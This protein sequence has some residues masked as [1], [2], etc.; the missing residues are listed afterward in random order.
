[1][2]A[3]GFLNS[4]PIEEAESL[5]DVE[6]PDPKP[7]VNDLLVEIEAVSVNPADAKRRIR[8]AVDT[9][10]ETP[11]IL[12]Y[13]AVGIVVECGANV[14]GFKPGDRVWYAGDANRPGSYASL[15]CVDHRI[16]A[17]APKNVS[18]EAAASLPLVSLTA[19]EILF[20]RLQV[21]QGET[22]FSLL[23]IGGAGG[24][25]SITAQIARKLTN[26]TVIAT[27]SRP[28]TAKWCRQM[29]AHHVVNHRDL[30]K[31]MKQAGLHQAD[32]IVQY[33]DT[34][35]HWD[36][37]CELIAPQGRIG[38][39]VETSEKLDI[40]ALQGKSA[41]LMWELMFTRSLFG[42]PDMYKQGHILAHMARM[43]DDGTIA[44]TE[45][46]V[47]HGLSSDTLKEAHQIIEGA[48]MIGKLVIKY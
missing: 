10:H 45:T 23:I 39:I 1:M 22:P 2:R 28:E 8:T 16:A 4:L 42:T 40:S 18:P 34:A 29:G 44:T 37:M 21:P 5:F 7:E 3:V 38:T 15:Q 17:H 41:A 24:V 9:P 27:A 30:V 43:V 31:D 32:Y 33:A 36:A 6:L 47:L 48:A 35:Q 25:G 12:G 20:E 19:W 14:T 13:D 46:K 11:F 26:A